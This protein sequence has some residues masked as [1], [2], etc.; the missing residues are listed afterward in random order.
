MRARLS[1]EPDNMISRFSLFLAALPLLLACSATLR[2]E[3]I[4]Y[5]HDDWELVCDNTRTCRAAGYSEEGAN[6]RVS[7]LLTRAAGPH[8]AVLG[9]I[10]LG[11]FGNE[12][13]AF[14]STLPEE[15]KLKLH[16]N[17]HAI[18][19][20]IIPRNSLVAELP[21]QQLAALLSNLSNESDIKWS[22]GNETWQL[23]G[24][25]A[26]NVLM[27]M[28]AFQG[29]HG[30]P[31]ALLD[32]GRRD[33]NRALPP[34]APLKIKP[35]L[36][37]PAQSA[38]HLIAADPIL[39]E[40]L[41]ATGDCPDFANGEPL[42]ISV[43]RLSETRL[44]A[45]THCWLAAYNSGIGFWLINDKAPFQPRLITTD[46]SEYGNGIIFSSHKGRGPGD[47]W[48]SDEWTWDG[49]D[50]VH[51]ASNSSGMCR[52]MAPGGAWQLPLIN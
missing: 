36:P 30:T 21:K 25:G 33:E 4:A 49:Q 26:I 32:K 51:T 7:V 42:Q 31:G 47:C 27:K 44:L 43:S 17:G 1:D 24:R 5:N 15:I 8:K 11:S 2:A 18:S 52:L 35:V 45:S 12:D 40:T 46:G 37:V 39:R 19:H 23:S 48:S 28:D 16:I 14:F 29:R 20:V 38:D 6:R 3:G 9:Q 10:M 22:Y 41:V 34:L 50:F 13:E